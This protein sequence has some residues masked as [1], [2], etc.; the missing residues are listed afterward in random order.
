M[1]PEGPDKQRALKSRRLRNPKRAQGLSLGGPDPPKEVQPDGIVE[2]FVRVLLFWIL[3][4]GLDPQKGLCFIYH[5]GNMLG[6]GIY[7]PKFTVH[8]VFRVLV[9]VIQPR[10]R[11]IKPWALRLETLSLSLSIYI[12]PLYAIVE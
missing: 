2:V 3:P 9:P 8:L 1:D 5:I 4:Y 11:R 12:H 7:G 6:Y 10:P